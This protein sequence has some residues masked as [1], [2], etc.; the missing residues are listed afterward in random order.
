MELNTTKIWEAYY[1]ELYFFVLKRVQNVDTANDLVQNIFIKIHKN[2]E[3]LKNS[4]KAKQ[5]V[6]QIARN[7]ILDFH[8][9]RKEELDAS[10]LDD[11]S[12]E[13]QF[14][15]ICC[16]DKFMDELPEKYKVVINSVYVEGKKLSQIA[17]EQ[18]LSLANVKARVRRGKQYL[19]EKL[20][21]CCKYNLDENGKLKGKP[22]CPI[23]EE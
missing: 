6:F 22:N 10:R 17:T 9:Q 19:K 13:D 4:Q 8:K 14:E 16:F 18:N 15:V 20:I 7:E 12:L 2:L 11:E 3:T 5:W 21:N 23:C 1:L